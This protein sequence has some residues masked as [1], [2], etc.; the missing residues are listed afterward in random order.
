M[1]LFGKASIIGTALGV[2]AVFVTT[3]T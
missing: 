2:L 1:T 3:T